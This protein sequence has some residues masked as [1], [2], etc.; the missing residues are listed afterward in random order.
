MFFLVRP[1][2]FSS[3]KL[4][5]AGWTD[6][7]Y[8]IISV[9]FKELKKILF[10]HRIYNEYVRMRR[11]VDTLRSRLIGT[12]EVLRENTRFEKLL[13]FK[14][15]LIYSSVMANVIARDP[16]NWNISF[17]IDRGT[18]DGVAP[19]MPVVSAA[20]VVGKVVEAGAKYS[21][22]IVLTDSQFSVPA[23][24]QASRESGLISGSLQ[25]FCRLR[26]LSTS[27]EVQLGE[28]VVTSKLSSSFPE[29]LLIGEVTGVRGSP[30]SP[31]GMEFIVKPAVALSK[32]EEVLVIQ[33]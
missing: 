29:G 1:Q 12:E 15:K 26:Y 10:Y 27:A 5:M 33:K 23:T 21:R 28:K 25:G 13:D 3:F 6:L 4:S 18:N 14:R 22:V 2:A 31:E 32:L 20:G 17:I 11:E 8:K 30:D 9:P 7:P 16:T 24:L 19:G